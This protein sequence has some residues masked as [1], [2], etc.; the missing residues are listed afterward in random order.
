MQ[1][2]VCPK[3]RCLRS[4]KQ[5]SS[6]DHIH[7]TDA[8]CVTVKECHK[9]QSMYHALLQALLANSLPCK[10]IKSLNCTPF[11]CCSSFNSCQKSAWFPLIHPYRSLTGSRKQET[12]KTMLLGMTQQKLMVNPSFPLTSA[13]TKGAV[14]GC[15]GRERED[16]SVRH[17]DKRS[18]STHASLWPEQRGR[19]GG[20]GEQEAGPLGCHLEVA[21]RRGGGDPSAHLGSAGTAHTEAA[22]LADPESVS[23]MSPA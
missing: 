14:G 5:C 17:D 16:Y 13:K 19:A 15:L 20:G 10:S 6:W 12:E 8:V 9:Q 23:G 21:G 3:D 22:G 7:N 4:Q 18:W 1:S 2:L 11:S